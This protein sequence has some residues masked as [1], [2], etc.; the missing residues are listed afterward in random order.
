M[1]NSRFSI[2]LPLVISISICA[3]FLICY[4]VMGDVFDAQKKS[5]GVQKLEDVLNLLDSK[6]V[7]P[8]DRDAVFEETISEMLHKLDPHSN[9][10]P[11]KDMAL[12]S[13]SI[14]GNFSGIGVRFFKLRDT[15]SIT[16]VLSNS[17]SE[18]AGLKDG[19]QIVRINGKNAAG[20]K[21]STDTIMSL[22]KGKSGSSVNVQI[23]R[24]GSL[25]SK[26][27]VRGRIPIKSI[28]VSYM[29]DDET[30][31]IKI[32]Q[33]SIPTAYEFRQASTNL[34]SQGMKKLVLDL[35]NNGGGVLDGATQIADE[36]LKDGLSIVKTQGRKIGTKYYTSTSRGSLKKTELVV[37]INSRSA[38]ASEIVAGA[39]QDNDRGLIIGRRSF[40]KGLVQEDQKLRDGSSLRIT[41]ARYY[42]P[43]GRCIQRPYSD[44]MEDYYNDPTRTE[45]SMFKVDSSIFIDSLKYKTIGG[46][47]VYGGG[48][49]SPDIFVP[50]DTTGT[51]VYYSALLWGGAVNQFAYDYVKRNRFFENSPWSSLNEFKTQ[52]VAEKSLIDELAEYAA[53]ELG[54]LPYQNSDIKHCKKKLSIQ[55]KSEIARQIWQENGFFSVY[56]D[57]DNEV[58]EARSSL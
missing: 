11:A 39:I 25:L 43:S 26:K 2:V 31:Y 42:T 51:G 44:G 53:Q 28:N 37:L 5:P 6:Y 33:F 4:V 55:L 3:G 9:Y 19:D 15:I 47:T 58:L 10:I 40:G 23:N 54:I 50:L 13:E 16:H 49:I 18:K 35:R 46:R 22:L 38:S 30:G 34:L 20:V 52:F 27:I 36:F 41:V 57:F 17:P 45:E 1:N 21:M 32:D 12:M 48:G 7:D 56:N 24:Y 8:I 14:E 29:I